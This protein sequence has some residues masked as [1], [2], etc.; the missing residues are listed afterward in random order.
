MAEV[1]LDKPNV[2]GP[3]PLHKVKLY[4]FKITNYFTLRKAKK[5]LFFWESFPKGGW[6]GWL[7]P[8]QGLEI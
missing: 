2:V 3:R 6:V 1:E 5:L 8:K 7:I 4:I